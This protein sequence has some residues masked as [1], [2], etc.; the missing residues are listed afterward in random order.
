MGLE[1]LGGEGGSMRD[2]IVG[3]VS[4][5]GGRD[6]RSRVWTFQVEAYLARAHLSAIFYESCFCVSG[7]Q[8]LERHDVHRDRDACT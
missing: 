4:E 1:E 3:I 6:L 2:D 7:P 5:M 8:L